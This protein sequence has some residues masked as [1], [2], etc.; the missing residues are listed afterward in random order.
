MTRRQSKFI[1]LSDIAGSRNITDRKRFEKKLAATLQ[2]VQQQY[3]DVFEMPIQVW[4]GLDETAAMLRAP[5]QLYNVMDAVDEGIAPLTMRFVLVRG[6]VDTMPED[7][8][9]SKADGEAFHI[10]A[11]R[12]LELKKEDLKFSCATGDADFDAAWQGQLNLL[13]LLKRGWTARQRIIYRMYRETALQ[14]VVAKKLGISQQTVSKTLKS[15]YAAQ[16]QTLEKNIA[17]WTEQQLRQ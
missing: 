1:L 2:Q 3:A 15:I 9:I 16:V 6:R 11:A 12:M 8:N 5:W 13:W 4:K 17:H 7:G 10:A 14:D